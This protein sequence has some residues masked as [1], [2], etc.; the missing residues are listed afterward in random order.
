MRPS[1]ITATGAATLPDLDGYASAMT[2]FRFMAS[3][4]WATEE[5]VAIIAAAH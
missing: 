4:V 5:T 2:N 3:H 1:I